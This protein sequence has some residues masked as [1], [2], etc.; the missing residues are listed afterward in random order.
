MFHGFVLLVT[1]VGSSPMFVT[2]KCHSVDQLTSLARKDGERHIE[3]FKRTWYT[4]QCHS[5]PVC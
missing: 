2:Y 5:P 1:C 4:L 3:V